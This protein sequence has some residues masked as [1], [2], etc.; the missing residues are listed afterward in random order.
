MNEFNKYK[1]L[2]NK[3]KFDRGTYTLKI[4]K[5]FINENSTID[6]PVKGD[7]SIKGKTSKTG[8]IFSNFNNNKTIGMNVLQFL[9]LLNENNKINLTEEKIK[10]FFDL[11]FE[12]FLMIKDNKINL[13]EE[14][15]EELKNQEK[16]KKEFNELFLK[17]LIGI[18]LP[19]SEYLEKRKIQSTNNSF[20][21]EIDAS[22]IKMLI[23]ELEKELSKKYTEIELKNTLMSFDKIEEYL[24]EYPIVFFDYKFNY[25][26][27]K[28]ELSKIVL[29]NKESKSTDEYPKYRL[30]GKTNN[31]VHYEKNAVA[32]IYIEGTTDFFTLKKLVLENKIPKVNI[33]SEH[34]ANQYPGNS[35]NLFEQ[36]PFKIVIGDNDNAGK[37]YEQMIENY[38]YE[39]NLQ[40][41]EVD[42]IYTSKDLGIYR[43]GLNDINE[44]YVK[45]E[46]FLLKTINNFIKTTKPKTKKIDF[47]VEKI[48]NNEKNKK[49]QKLDLETFED[50]N[51]DYLYTYERYNES[52]R[53]IPETLTT[54]EQKDLFF[55]VKTLK[56][57]I[58]KIENKKIENKKLEK[59]IT[60]EEII[61]ILEKYKLQLSKKEEIDYVNK[62]IK[63]F[64][65]IKKDINK[66]ETVETL[67]SVA[68]LTKNI[69]EENNIYF[70]VG[71][72]SNN[73][74]ILY[75]LGITNL[76]PLDHTDILDPSLLIND[77]DFEINQS[78]INDLLKNLDFFIKRGLVKNKNGLFSEHP[79]KYFFNIPKQLENLIKYSNE[80]IPMI[81]KDLEKKYNVPNIDYIKR[82]YDFIEN[83]Y[84]EIID[85]K[86]IK[87]SDELSYSDLYF[88]DF[89]HFNDNVKNHIKYLY[90]LEDL[91]SNKKTYE[92]NILKYKKEEELVSI[93]DKELIDFS[94][95][96][97][98]IELLEDEYILTLKSK[99]N[100]FFTVLFSNNK[101][102]KPRILNVFDNNKNCIY[103]KED[104]EI[105]VLHFKSESVYTYEEKSKIMKNLVFDK[106]ELSNFVSIIRPI[107]IKPKLKIKA[108][109]NSDRIDFI[110]SEEHEN[111][112]NAVIIEPL[113]SSKYKLIVKKENKKLI[114]IGKI[115]DNKE[116]ILDKDEYKEL[117][118]EYEERYLLNMYKNNI[119]KKLNLPLFLQRTKGVIINQEVLK[120]TLEIFKSNIFTDK[121]IEDVIQ[122]IAHPKKITSEMKDNVEKRITSLIIE[123]KLPVSKEYKEY[124]KELQEILI[125]QVL[126][127]LKG[128]EMFLKSAHTL[129]ITNQ[130]LY[131]NALNRALFFQNNKNQKQKKTK[132]P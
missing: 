91:D 127:I 81:S 66:K 75:I 18:K 83:M 94:K 108:N 43:N 76:Q 48:S 50:M 67:F 54:Q 22:K 45:D 102:K 77:I 33:I 78:R 16:I 131:I 89:P 26:E 30:F 11:S 88:N 125:K 129:N 27:N 130:A 14:E 20:P 57:I 86:Q 124:E 56:E 117:D 93:Y 17:K 85:K 21:F 36:T 55:N 128:N 6:N 109:L 59:I 24:Y 34:S 96:N 90:N 106:Y 101:E 87:Q 39:T 115:I 42:Y 69:C 72:S 51:K 37:N 31:Y 119:D 13:T 52:Y 107:C 12:E 64:E 92:I 126:F 111:I 2:M 32:S 15:K 68:L 1:E 132:Y 65:V 70:N 113:E 41:N 123:K 10:E 104:L 5:Y 61:N 53:I 4:L 40:K 71:G 105:E 19:H 3:I 25:K 60:I 84:N 112:E 29:R 122:R 38:Y 100:K 114:L 23:K 62:E 103:D 80:T 47:I 110:E 28:Q 7:T 44:L 95:E 97:K 82:N 116:I 79:T 35:F 46:D 121:D 49:D 63:T 8:I 99:E 9:Y 98:N 74:L 58:F 118:C 120:K 73:K